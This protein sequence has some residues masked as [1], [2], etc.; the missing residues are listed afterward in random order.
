MSQTSNRPLTS[1]SSKYHP[2]HQTN[3]A[4][5]RF[6]SLGTPSLAPGQEKTRT[7]REPP[8]VPSQAQHVPRPPAAPGSITEAP[9]SPGQESIL[10]VLHC[11]T[12]QVDEHYTRFAE[13]FVQGTRYQLETVAVW[14]IWCITH[15]C[16]KPR[17]D[18]AI[19]TLPPARCVTIASVPATRGLR[20]VFAHSV[21]QQKPFGSPS[22][23]R[24]GAPKTS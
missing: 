16:R 10:S 15:R 3:H 12:R 9:L 11:A 4:P 22:Q 20:Y 6:P 8:P 24:C 7:E 13:I 21:S 17:L 23:S 19:N 14:N 5:A 18:A 2:A 1:S